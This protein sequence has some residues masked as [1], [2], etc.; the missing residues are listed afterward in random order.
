MATA[1]QQRVSVANRPNYGPGK[2]QNNANQQRKVSVVN[3]RQTD[4]EHS[5]APKQLQWDSQSQNSACACDKHK[6]VIVSTIG[7]MI[8]T[9]GIV[10]AVLT[11]VNQYVRIVGFVLTGVGAFITITGIIVHLKNHKKHKQV[12]DE[13]NMGTD[14]G[15]IIDPTMGNISMAD[16]QD[17]AAPDASQLYTSDRKTRTRKKSKI[18]IPSSDTDNVKDFDSE[19]LPGLVPLP[20]I[21]GDT[22]QNLKVPLVAYPN[23]PRDQGDIRMASATY[24]I[25][26]KTNSDIK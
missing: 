17:E 5:S 26:M 14:E 13:N 21:A 8:L 4:G 24:Q 20:V 9:I 15:Y 19:T 10:L 7:V 22:P 6:S 1:R 12:Q 23:I 18:I 2:G 3:L 25:A 16:I 11:S